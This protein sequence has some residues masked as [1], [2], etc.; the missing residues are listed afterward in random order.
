M[1]RYNPVIS[2]LP[3]YPQQ[4]LNRR[5]A[6]V[7]AEGKV[8]YDF[9]VG[10]PVE[11]VPEFIRNA[12]KDAV[13]P[14]CG[15]P[16]VLGSQT[17]R[18]SIVGYVKRRYGCVLDPDRH[19][20]PVSGAKEAVFH[21]PM[22][23]ID[24]QASDRHVLFPDPG[25]PAYYRGALF[26]G[27]VPHPIPL[28]GDYVFRPWRLA[29]E[30]LQKTRILWLNSPHNPSGVSMSHEDLQ[31]TADICRKYDIVCISD[32]TYADIYRETPP[33][34]LLEGD[35]ENTLVIHS[36]SK[37][38]GMTG[39]RSGFVAGDPD[40]IAKLVAFRANPGLVPQ[41][42]VNAAAEKAWSD[43]EHVAQRRKVFTQK[44]ELF[45]S[46][47]DGKGWDVLGRD[48]SLY[49]WLRVPT[50]QTGEEY[51]LDL[52]TLGIVVSP[53]SM[54]AI[55]DAGTNYVRLAMVPDIECCAKAISIWSDQSQ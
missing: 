40:I 53:G 15:Y 22:L 51:A 13:P 8:L 11:P 52:L 1:P 12:L 19:V 48:A 3:T 23:F 36:L 37:R 42:F 16:K 25:Y 43:D 46:F 50:D 14:H 55:T 54:F 24:P 44:K 21:A 5:K 41:T 26:A 9:G 33:A 27:G 18:N 30:L 2:A 38:S 39:Y 45:L 7:R 4:A 6:Q 35:L 47:F 10:D 34:S 28:E 32:E 49:L 31:K 20:V 29:P 17:L